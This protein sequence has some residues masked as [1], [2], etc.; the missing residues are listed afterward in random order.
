MNAAALV[1]RQ[2]LESIG[3]NV[4]LRPMDWSTYLTARARKDPPEKGGW[5]LLLTWWMAA[6]VIS[7]A[8]H[9]GLSGAGSGAWF[10]WP[11]IPQLDKLTTDWLRATDP[12][13]RK[14]I[15]EEIQKTALREVSY[16][17]WGEWVQPTAYRKNVQGILKF[18]APVFWN[19]RV[20]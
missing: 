16:V 1:T 13:R 15:A 3:F 19:V 10:G 12:A 11:D 4:I 17:P 2:R 18:T 14:Q 5:S 6:D 20:T 8:V 7:P 9:F